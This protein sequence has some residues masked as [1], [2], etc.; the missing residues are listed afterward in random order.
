MFGPPGGYT[1]PTPE[2][3]GFLQSTPIKYLRSQFVTITSGTGTV[4]VNAVDTDGN[5]LFAAIHHVS[6]TPWQTSG[7]LT[8]PTITGQTISSDLKT[9]TAY[10]TDA[11]DTTFTVAVFGETTGQCFYAQPLATR[12]DAE[13]LRSHLVLCQILLRHPQSFHHGH[14]EAYS[15]QKELS[16]IGTTGVRPS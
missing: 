3:Q 14:G 8:V 13:S 10:A 16:G 2:V 7:S 12:H 6:F 1:P 9:I 5:A 4:T 11:S 15:H